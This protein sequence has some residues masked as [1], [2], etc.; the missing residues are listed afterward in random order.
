VKI[1]EFLKNVALF[2]D[3]DDV[4]LTM[5]A[6]QFML[7][8]Y[9]RNSIVFL[10]TDPGEQF[11]VVLTGTVRVYRIAEDGREMVLDIFTAGDYFGEMALLDGYLRSATAQ[12]RE[13]TQLLVM[14][15]DNFYSLEWLRGGLN[16]TWAVTG[17][18][19]VDG[20]KS[21]EDSPGG[22][23][24]NNQLDWVWYNNRIPHQEDSHCVLSFKIRYELEKDYDYFDVL[25]SPDPS[26]GFWILDYLTGSSG[27]QLMPIS[28]TM[29]SWQDGVYFGFG[30]ETD[31]MVTADGVC[32]DDLAVTVKRISIN[33]YDYA[34]AYGTSMAAPYVAGI[35]AL[36]LSVEP[37]L[38]VDQ[39]K[40]LILDGADQKPALA[41][42]VVTGGRINAYNSLSLLLDSLDADMNRDGVVDLYDLVIVARAMGSTPGSDGWL[43][44]A[45]VNGDRVVCMLDLAEVSLRYGTVVY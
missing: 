42:K 19:G 17:G 36:L 45:D 4:D 33:G 34:F 20:S 5:V 8:S 35:A 12:T 21:L 22:H 16:N 3:L 25:V 29:P 43:L 14:S 18:T 32:I 41:G 39:L 6:K 27:G 13:P 26:E 31:D 28:V 9:P 30:I 15:G 10:E 2:A 1:K 7:R 23:Y 38:T 24:Q 44:H 37:H 40:Q 11:Y